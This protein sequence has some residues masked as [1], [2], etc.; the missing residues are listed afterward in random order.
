M[1]QQNIVRFDTLCQYLDC[2]GQPTLH[3]LV[4]VVDLSTSP[5]MEHYL[6]SFGFYAVFLKD[7]KC[8][9]LRYGRQYYDYQE[10]TLV[11]VAPG[12]VLGVEPDGETF[13]PKGYALLFHPELLR[14]TSL[15]SNLMREYT[16]FS[17]AS[18]EALHL[19][20]QERETILEC[21]HNIEHELQHAVDRHSR[22]LVVSNIELLLNYCVRFYDRQFY[23]REAVNS[24]IL[25]RFER[26]LHDYFASERPEREGLPTVGMMAD[27]L[28][29]S[30]NYLGDLIKKQTGRTAQE[31]I[32]EM[33]VEIAKERIF[34]P[35]K[36]VSQIAYE[37]G[38]KYPQHF[39]R[40]FKRRT[41]LTPVEYR[42]AN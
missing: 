3:P 29:L 18:N 22:R 26:N 40:L 13:Q 6:H 9:D 11:F 21:L 32:Q 34:D 28:H 31:H 12:Q 16:F 1:D 2:M 41:G 39:T 4:A 35:S 25:S 23:T 7:A 27:E 5:R 15:G 33:L 36:S 42:S 24:D 8:G 20:E 30:A 19:S 17:Y 10:G 14:G 37:M 38:F